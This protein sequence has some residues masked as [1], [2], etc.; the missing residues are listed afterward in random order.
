MFLNSPFFGFNFL[1]DFDSDKQNCPV[2]GPSLMSMSLCCAMLVCSSRS[3][4]LTELVEFKDFVQKM[5]S[6]A[7]YVKWPFT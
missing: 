4:T 7:G 1:A 2:Q 3:F 5:C 6:F